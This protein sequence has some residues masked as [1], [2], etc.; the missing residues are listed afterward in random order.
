MEE[1]PKILGGRLTEFSLSGLGL[2]LVVGIPGS[3]TGAVWVRGLAEGLAPVGGLWISALRMTVIP[4]VLTQLLTALTGPTGK[5]PIGG[6]GAKTFGLFLVFLLSIGSL[7]LVAVAPIMNLAPV[8]AETTADL[9]SRMPIPADVTASGGQAGVS[10]G[11]WVR[12][13]VPENVFAAAAAGDILPLLVFTILFG[14]AANTLGPRH[15]SQLG[16]LF[17]ALATVMM[18]VVFWVLWLTPLAV[19]SLVLELSLAI[20]GAALGTLLFYVLTVAAWM[21]IVS[22]ALY[23]VA[24]VLGRVSLR[25]FARALAPAHMVAVSTR[26]SLASLPALIEGGREHLRFPSSIT[27]FVLPLCT[28]LFKLSTVTAE[29]VRYLFLAHLFG[30]DLTFP[31]TA[32]FLLTLII[33][34]FSGVGVPRG[35]SGFDTLPAYVAAGIPIEGLV[36]VVAVDT[37]PDVAKTI[38]NV[39]GHM[40][41]ATITNRKRRVA[42]G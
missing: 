19:F 26:S 23:P 8:D 33:L 28:S 5:E 32:T 38:I 9:L 40:S 25:D 1:T 22:G 37:L 36:L 31:Q 29:P 3:L 10:P 20:G 6:L 7:T 42:V 15:R 35:G 27:G 41:V 16:D 21:L 24:A 18:Q 39:T 13:L 2:A 14:L 4:L 17:G 11:E 30:I 12:G 34:S